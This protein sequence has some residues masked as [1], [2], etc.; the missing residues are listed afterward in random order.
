MK[1]VNNITMINVLANLVL[2]FITLVSGFIIPK[3]I[4]TTFGSSVNGLIASINQLLSYITLVEGGITAVVTA[5]LYKPLID[6]DDNKISTIIKTSGRFYKKIGLFFIIYSI[7]LAVIYPLYYSNFEFSYV[8]ILS[9]TLILSINSLIQYMMSLS[10]RTLLNADK[11]V[12]I[13]S[14]VQSIIFIINIVL[15][16]L[17]V[18]VFPNIH[19]LKFLTGITYVLQPIFYKK[20]IKMNYNIDKNVVEDIELIKDRWSGF[21]NNFAY[22]IHHST[23]VTILTFATNLKIVSIYSVYTLVTNGLKSIINAISGAISPSVGQLFAKGNKE[24]LDRKFDI[25]EYINFMI[26]FIVFTISIPLITPFVMIYVGKVTDANY[27]QPIFG[28]LLIIAT[29]IDLL[30]LPHLNLS[31]SARK[32]KE[33]TKPSFIEAILNISISI[34]LVKKYSLNGIIIG[35]MIAVLYRMIFH[36]SYTKKIIGRNQ[37]K[38]YKKL[39]ICLITS[40]MSLCIVYSIIPSINYNLFS[41]IISGT[42]IF[43]IVITLFIISSMIFMKDEFDYIKKVFFSFLKKI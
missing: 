21:I 13:V 33:L 17:C 23:D 16:Y 6:K 1:K 22:F 25:Y 34:L 36:I 29:M 43:A 11:K 32:F 2:Q 28:V 12:Y 8:Y 35:T 9:L 39:F 38:F 30:K 20:Y 41:W 27:N 19:F 4:I 15:V 10:L 14:N 18:K 26:I 3:L 7:F 5:S 31:Y 37:S 42:I 24:E 40:I